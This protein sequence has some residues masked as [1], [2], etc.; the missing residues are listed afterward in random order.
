MENEGQFGNTWKVHFLWC[1]CCVWKL[2]NSPLSG[3]WL[4]SP[5][6][7]RGSSYTGLLETAEAEIGGQKRTMG[8]NWGYIKPGICC[9]CGNWRLWIVVGG[10]SSFR[11]SETETHILCG[12]GDNVE[13]VIRRFD[14]HPLKHKNRQGGFSIKHSTQGNIWSVYLKSVNLCQYLSLCRPEWYTWDLRL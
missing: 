14:I 6:R 4:G 2:Q 11:L 1:G 5:H 3:G 7:L 9:H 10:V 12:S 8:T 13:S